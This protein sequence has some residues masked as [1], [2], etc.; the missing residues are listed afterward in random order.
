MI[1]YPAIDIKDGKCVRLKQ[2]DF[3]QVTEFNDDVLAQAQEFEKQGFEWLHVVDLD[4]ARQGRPINFQLVEKIIRNT[5]LKVQVG[6]GIRDVHAINKVISYGAA[7][8]VLGTAAIENFDLVKKA[9]NEYPGC[10]A[11]G[12]DARGNKVATHGW[13]EEANDMLVF[14]LIDKLAEVGVSAIVYT[15]VS[16]DGLLSGFDEQGT[17]E[18]AKGIAVP[19]IASGG[20]S[21]VDDLK[22]LEQMKQYGVE[23]V[24]IGRAFY[25]SKISFS[26]ALSF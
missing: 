2:G 9:C 3:S 14:D 19:I 6:G 7:R 13:Q 12:V 21:S 4:G 5:S 18:I 15:D 11:V 24:I 1:I 25:E 8:V 16:R 10:I 17:R 26:D 20:V 22:K 23:G